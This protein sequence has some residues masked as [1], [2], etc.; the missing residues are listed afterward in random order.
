VTLLVECV[1]NVSEGRDQQII[2]QLIMVIRETPQVQ[3]LHTTSDADH[4][5]SVF[6]FVGT[7]NG[8]SEAAF[9]LVQKAAELIDLRQHCG[10]HPRIG[11]ADVVPFVPIGKTPLEVCVALAHALGARVGTELR[12]PVYLYEAAALRPERRLL[13][14]V[15]RGGYEGLVASIHLPERAPDFGPPQVGSAGAVII[16]ARHPLI[17][18]NVFLATS[19]AAIARKIARAIRESA[20]GLPAVRALGFLVGGQAQVSINLTDYRVTSLYTVMQAVTKWALHYGTAVDRSELI[21]LIPERAALD[22]L[23]AYLKLPALSADQILYDNY[24]LDD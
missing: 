5:R 7:P 10:Q 15:R 2:N 3:L 12:L 8:V 22:A 23:A 11:A 1:P 17:A 20:G 4:H 14:D 16:G 18:Y 6:T 24:R 13:A 19:D 21:G 9:R